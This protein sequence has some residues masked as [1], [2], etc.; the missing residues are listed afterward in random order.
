VASFRKFINLSNHQIV[1][2]N[3]LNQG[4]CDHDL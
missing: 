3:W 4:I 1:K 2:S